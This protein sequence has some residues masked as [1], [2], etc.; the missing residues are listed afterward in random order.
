MKFA[1]NRKNLAKENGQTKV[2]S[3]LRSNHIGLKGA[4]LLSSKFSEEWGFTHLTSSP[5]YP[6]SNGVAERAGQ[7]V[8]NLL[9]KSGDPY[10]AMLSYP[11]TRL[12]NGISPAQL[13]MGRKL[14]TTLP[15]TTEKLQPSWP[16]LADLQTKEASYKKQESQSFNNY[17]RARNLPELLPGNKVWLT[18]Q[19]KSGM[20][21]VKSHEPPLIYCQNRNLTW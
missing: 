14:R 20:V 10:L 15:V 7:T 1:S 5:H 12:H 2:A 19:R 13:L 17:H 16:D 18:D 21:T 4:T 11:P 6:Q 3:G 8:K 9:K